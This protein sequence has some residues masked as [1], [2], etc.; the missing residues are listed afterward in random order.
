[1][2][3]RTPLSVSSGDVATSRS[4]SSASC[5][6]G[7]GIASARQSG[8]RRGVSG[9]NAR[10]LPKIGVP[11]RTSS[12]E[13]HLPPARISP[14]PWESVRNGCASW[15]HPRRL[16]APSA[17]PL[18]AGHDRPGVRKAKDAV[19]LADLPA[20]THG[21]EFVDKRA[22]ARVGLIPSHSIAGAREAPRQLHARRPSDR[23]HRCYGWLPFEI[24]A[25]GRPEH[26]VLV[27]EP[28]LAGGSGNPGRR[29]PPIELPRV[30]GVN[31]SGTLVAGV[32]RGQARLRTAIRPVL[33]VLRALRSLSLAR[34]AITA[35]RSGDSQ[36]C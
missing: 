28:C 20:I 9:T 17:R 30:V 35:S 11:R 25:F 4:T 27:R 34:S 14:P 12:G 5:V 36:S 2:S 33:R 18:L 23:R 16:R 3:I 22:G 7:V 8:S 32:R 31:R 21:L 15:R 29:D 26:A 10:R 1:M 6:V 24:R 13:T 19:C